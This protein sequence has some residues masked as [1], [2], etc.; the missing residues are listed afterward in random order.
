MNQISESNRLAGAVAKFTAPVTEMIDTKMLS[1]WAGAEQKNALK[2]QVPL[3][4]RK[5]VAELL[6][7]SVRT[8]D[9]WMVSGV[10]PY[11]KIG[12]VVRFKVS[13]IQEIRWSRKRLS[14]SRD[15][16]RKRRSAKRGEHRKS[17]GSFRK[18]K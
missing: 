18:Y 9:R 16:P 8:V 12:K 2:I 7:V 14:A 6:S 5:Q 13:D 11:Y 10:L 4:T 15:R 1:A 3:I 17:R